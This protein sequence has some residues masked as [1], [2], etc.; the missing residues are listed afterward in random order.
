MS[1]AANMPNPDRAIAAGREIL[2]PPMICFADDVSGNISKQ[3]NK[4]LNFY[5]VNA[6]LPRT[7][8]DKEYNV[9]FIATSSHAPVMEIYQGVCQSLKYAAACICNY[10]HALICPD[11]FY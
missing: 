9:K 11:P 6:A 2:C 7:E 1:F 8:V 10:T 4:H 3:Y 5:F